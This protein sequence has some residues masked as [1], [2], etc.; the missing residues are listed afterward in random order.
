MNK[1]NLK[2]TEMR[3]EEKPIDLYDVE[4]MIIL[5]NNGKLYSNQTGGVMC[6]HPTARGVFQPMSVPQFI[7]DEFL[8]SMYCSEAGITKCN[9][10]LE[11]I[12]A[13]Y[14]IT[15]GEE[16]WVSVKG[17]DFEGILTYENSD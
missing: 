6:G 9:E 10:L 13:P 5:D 14:R 7:K 11:S 15:G 17:L 4:G 2:S 16:A 12:N 8:D 1:P 3:K